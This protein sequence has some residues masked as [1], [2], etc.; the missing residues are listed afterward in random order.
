MALHAQVQCARSVLYEEPDRS[1]GFCGSLV[2]LPHP[3]KHLCLTA[4]LFTC[5]GGALT[6][7]LA[8]LE[9]CVACADE[10]FKRT[11]S[12]AERRLSLIPREGAVCL[13]CLFTLQLCHMHTGAGRGVSMVTRLLQHGKFGVDH[14]SSCLLLQVAKLSICLLEERPGMG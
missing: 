9:R 6:C 2:K 13:G 8:G 5:R 4:V 1:P 12:C 11:M 14:K 3:R 10:S 7:H